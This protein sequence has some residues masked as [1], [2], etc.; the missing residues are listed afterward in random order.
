M[1]HLVLLLALLVAARPALAEDKSKQAA[2]HYKQGKV[3]F[4]AKEYDRAIGEYQQAYDIDKKSA[5]LYNIARAYHLKGDPKSAME[6]YQKFLDVDPDSPQAQQVREYFATATREFTAI[7]GKRKAEEAAKRAEEDKRKHDADQEQKRVAATARI[8]QAEAYIS[9]KA[10]VAAGD[11]YKAAVEIDGDPAHLLEAAEAY[12]KQPD[13]EKARAAYLAYLD[14][15]PMGAQSDA[16]R[17]KVAEMTTAIDKATEDARQAK[18]REDALKQRV[19]APPIVEKPPRAHSHRGWIVVGG[20]LLLT[21]LVAD[22]GPP[23]ANNGKMDLSDLAGPVF[24]SLGAA[25]VLRGVF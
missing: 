6:F 21:G 9:A 20:A 23:N 15:V 19:F 3:F 1:K 4:D 25:A 8:R 2:S 14:K 22:L 5:H 13:P 17:G 12:R 16:V 7:E 10:W 18:L 24:Y 11:E